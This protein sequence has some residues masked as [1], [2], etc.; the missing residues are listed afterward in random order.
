MG[1]ADLITYEVVGP[2]PHDPDCAIWAASLGDPIV[3]TCYADDDEEE[4]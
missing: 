1:T 4:G 3:C 2:P